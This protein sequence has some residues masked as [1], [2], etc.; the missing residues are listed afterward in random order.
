MVSALGFRASVAASSAA[1][2]LVNSITSRCAFDS[3]TKSLTG[4]S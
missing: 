2:A 4:F 3:A 1:I